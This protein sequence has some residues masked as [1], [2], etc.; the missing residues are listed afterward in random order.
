MTNATAAPLA[1][2]ERIRNAAD[3]SVIVVYFVVV[4]AV[5][6]WVCEDPEI[7]SEGVRATRRDK[8]GHTEERRHR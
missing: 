2:H 8:G 5:G 3:I 4:M 6:L 7:W 1:A